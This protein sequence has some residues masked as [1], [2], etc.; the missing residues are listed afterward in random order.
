MIRLVLLAV[1]FVGCVTSQ[2][3]SGDAGTW[4]SEG[5]ERKTWDTGSAVTL[6]CESAPG[7]LIG[8]AFTWDKKV[9]RPFQLVNFDEDGD[10][11]GPVY[12]WHNNGQLS[13]SKEYIRGSLEGEMRMWHPNG[14]LAVRAQYRNDELEGAWIQ[15]RPDGTL[16]LLQ[17]WRQGDLNGPFF[18]WHENGRLK[19]IGSYSDWNEVGEWEH[20]NADGIRERDAERGEVPAASE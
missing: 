2:P 3:F 1:F 4:C 12:Y 5:L 19:T 14:T 8:A 20:W 18:A 16:H 10:L 11:H 13:S 7:V 9:G 15:W 17:H 6:A